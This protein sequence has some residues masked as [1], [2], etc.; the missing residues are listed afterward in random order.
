MKSFSLAL[1]A[2]QILSALGAKVEVQ[3][4]GGNATSGRQYGFLHE[5]INHSGD[6]GIYAELIRNRAFQYNEHYP[7]TLD[8]WF[9]VNGASLELRE[10]DEPLSD[11]LPVSM[12]V[13]KGKNYRHGKIGFRN[14]GYW[15]MDVKKQK[16]KG[17]F[18]V[19]GDYKGNF[20]ASLQSNNTND[21]FGA[22]KVKS[23]AR[24]DEW[25]EHKF[26]LT[27]W[28]NAPTSNNT[29]VLQFD[30]KGVKGDLDFNLISL[31]PP[32]FKDRENGLRKD[33]AESLYELHPSILRIPGGNMLEGLDNK[34]WW[35]WKD[36][37]YPLR[38]RKGFPGVWGYQQTYGLGMMEYLWWAEDM[39]L[40]LVVGVYAG[41]SM[42]GSITPEDELQQFIDDALDQIEFL[43]G[44]VDTKWGARRAEL[45]HPEPVDLHF[46]EIGNED[47]Y[48]GGQAGWDSYKEYRLPRFIEAISA[49]WPELTIIASGTHTDRDGIDLPE[50]IYGDYHPYK[51]PDVLVEEFDRFDNDG[52]HIIG[53]V[54][55]THVNGGIG[56]EGSLYYFPWWIGTVGEAVSMIGYERNADRVFATFYAPILRNMNFWNWSVTLVQFD[57]W[58]VTRSTSWYLWELFAFHPMSH[59]LPATEDFGPVYYV[60]GKN[61][62][63]GSFI[64]KGACYNTTNG[65]DQP[66]SVKF[67]GVQEGTKASLT[68][69]TNS[70]GD[71][72]RWNDPYNHTNIVDRS[73]VVLSA[74]KDGAFEFEMPELSIA[75]LDT[76]YKKEACRNKKA[77]QKRRSVEQPFAA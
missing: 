18:W 21:V 51:M 68:M 27:P 25:V 38:Y 13:S 77:K 45:G 57:A 76:D 31:F 55:A 74:N 14:D 3:S 11:V 12:K 72:M 4:S 75:V 37:L 63:Q 34:T 53:E 73:T 30:P 54:A 7:L 59:T 36:T 19:K 41:L 50:G 67:D 39:D 62:D 17:S 29:F 8:G 56:W 47:W 35:D 22:V 65:A 58:T 9:P 43:K 40:E 26:E 15:G 49:A 28:E 32:T 70:V 1:V 6:G 5:D 48:A 24:K 2:T 33:I 23:N 16:Y 20:E 66:V 71:P 10:L 52:P 46:V 69:L 42:D 64:W 61:E 60:A 44:G